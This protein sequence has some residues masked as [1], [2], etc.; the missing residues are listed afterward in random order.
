MASN[1]FLPAHFAAERIVARVGI[2][3]DTHMPERCAAFPASLF[4]V[5]RGVDM[6]LHAGDVGELW[7]LDR[8]SAIAPVI[9]VHGNDETPDAQRELPYQQ[10]LTVAGQR[11]L[12]WHCHYRDPA[13]EMASRG[14][15]W[16]PKLRRQIERGQR[17]G[18]QI[19]IFGHAHIPLVYQHDGVLLINSG[20]LASGGL[21]T[22]QKRQTV[23][24]LFIRDDGMP[25][26]VHVDLATPDRVYVPDV[27]LEAEFNVA[28]DASQETIV[29]PDLLPDTARL[30]KQTYSDISAIKEAILPLCHPCWAREKRYVTRAELLD[31]VERGAGIAPDDREKMI[32]ILSKKGA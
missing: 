23:A 17:A 10:L 32:A 2:I 9:A 28:L 3:S 11:V 13:A 18:A 15:D 19:V 16:G 22:R 7:V 24:L 5:L 25:L 31:A 6:I 20:A 21:F 29:E 12:L 30:S 14:G 1:A 27:D 8:L 26:V 4:D